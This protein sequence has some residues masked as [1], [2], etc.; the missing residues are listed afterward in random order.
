MS[1]IKTKL[2][3]PLCILFLLGDSGQQFIF[4]D[5][6]LRTGC[7]R[8]AHL[9]IECL[10]MNLVR[11]EFREEVLNFKK[12]ETGTHSSQGKRPKQIFFKKFP[13]KLQTSGDYP[14][15]EIQTSPQTHTPYS[16]KI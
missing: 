8:R 12:K 3:L 15:S 14:R 6:V 11:D 13:Y 16:L 7:I 9:Q 1:L 10:T 2:I 4:F 5:S